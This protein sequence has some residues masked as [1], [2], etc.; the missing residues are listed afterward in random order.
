MKGLISSKP[1]NDAEPYSSPFLKFFESC[2]FIYKSS[3][4]KREKSMPAAISLML[5][6]IMGRAKIAL[7]DSFI[8][9]S[10]FSLSFVLK[11]YDSLSP[12]RTNIA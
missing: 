8:L 7:I 11:R 10:I 2:I 4:I 9:M 12:V 5:R 6:L 1:P 3:L